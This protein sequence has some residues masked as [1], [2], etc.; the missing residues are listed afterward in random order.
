M[1]EDGTPQNNDPIQPLPSVESTVESTVD[2]TTGAETI[3]VTRPETSE[4]GVVAERYIAAEVKGAKASLL[5]T[6]IFSVLLAVLIGGY[7]IYLTQ[8]FRASLEPKEAATIATGLIAQRV[9]DQGGQL[10]DSLKTEVPK[11]IRQAPD[12]ALEQLPQIRTQIQNRVET[13]VQNYAEKSSEQF[14]AQM[15]TF[16][17]QNKEEVGELLKNGND[18]AATAKIAEGLKAEF[19][20]YL[21]TTQ[22]NG[23]TLK[24]KLDA[25]LG[26][27]DKA[28][29]RLKR[30]ATAKDLTPQEQSA[31]RAIAV[32]LSTVDQ[33]RAEFNGG[34]PLA[35]EP[36]A[37]AREAL[38]RANQA[39][40]E[41]RANLERA[42][43][44]LK[45]K[46][47]EALSQA[48]EAV[49]KAQDA[50]NRTSPPAPR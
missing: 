21:S 35:T 26:T 25:A 14:G 10:A 47:N 40:V 32:L 41:A 3:V 46:A 37:Q 2:P 33:K 45:A 8:R 49:N 50:V 38:Q 17:E 4:A 43:P 7:V 34:E 1:N 36:M 12:Y 19:V 24:A 30:L 13:E 6:Q 9:E 29:A 42:T 48:N 31:K 44:E 23:E 39:A 5:R 22:V 18:P 27:L 28:Q 16:L 11:Y 20:K 15:D